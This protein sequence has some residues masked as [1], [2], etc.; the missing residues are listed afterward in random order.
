MLARQNAAM[1]LL[2]S[3]DRTVPS[4]PQRSQLCSA[5]RSSIMAAWWRCGMLLV[6]ACSALWHKQAA[7]GSAAPCTAVGNSCAAPSGSTTW[8]ALRVPWEGAMFDGGLDDLAA[9]LSWH[10]P[11]R[12]LLPDQ[13]GPLAGPPLTPQSPPAPVAPSPP[14][15]DPRPPLQL[16]AHVSG[17]GVPR[18][19]DM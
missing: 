15:P 19:C 1:L 9:V 5:R 12:M 10:A 8:R 4:C 18:P 14:P 2:L 7:A 6:V 3:P 13:V 17:I 16:P 11:R